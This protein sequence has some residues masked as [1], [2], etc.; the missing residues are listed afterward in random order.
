MTDLNSLVVFAEIVEANSLSEAARRL[1]NFTD[2]CEG[3]GGNELPTQSN[4]ALEAASTGLQ[5][6]A[7]AAVHAPTKTGEEQ[8]SRA[9]ELRSVASR[10]REPS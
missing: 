7:L 4:L 8:P 9:S 3:A 6:I 10:K 1:Q 5:A 2:R